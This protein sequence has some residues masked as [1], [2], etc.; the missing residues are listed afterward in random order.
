MYAVFCNGCRPLYYFIVTYDNFFVNKIFY[1]L[2]FCIFGAIIAIDNINT[3][4]KLTP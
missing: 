3:R 4:K 2:Y 1:F